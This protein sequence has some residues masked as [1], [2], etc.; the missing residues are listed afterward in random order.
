MGILVE[1]DDRLAFLRFF[2]FAAAAPFK[3]IRRECVAHDVSTTD[4]PTDEPGKW[5]N[6]TKGLELVG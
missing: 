2:Y 3:A 1:L 4:D 5:Q 6:A